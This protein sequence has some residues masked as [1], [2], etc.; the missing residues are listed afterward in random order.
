[1]PIDIN[2]VYSQ[3]RKMEVSLKE[4]S[5]ANYHYYQKILTKCDLYVSVISKYYA[6]AKQEF[7]QS[8]VNYNILE[9]EID[10]KRRHHIT[11]DESIQKKYS[12]GREREMA[13]EVLL[14]DEISQLKKKGN[15][16]ILLKDLCGVLNTWLSIMR[17]RKRDAKEQWK[18]LC[19]QNKASNMPDATDK[20]VK[21]LNKVIGELEA[22]A[23]NSM[24]EDLQIDE[25]TNS[26]EYIEDDQEES[27]DIIDAAKNDDSDVD[28]NISDNSEESEDI[29]IS[30]FDSNTAETI[31]PPTETAVSDETDPDSSDSEDDG[32]DILD[33]L[34]SDQDSSAEEV[35]SNQTLESPQPG[36]KEDNKSNDTLEDELLNDL[37]EIDE[38]IIA[39]VEEKKKRKKGSKKSGKSKKSDDTTVTSGKSDQEQTVEDS[40]GESTSDTDTQSRQKSTENP[41]NSPPKKDNVPNEDDASIANDVSIEDILGDL[42][43][44]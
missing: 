26:D 17:E 31:E 28:V 20:D 34:S 29:D 35:T 24:D 30:D 3:L 8:Q 42:D 13:V 41:G 36:A 16:L 27:E 7:S 2:A 14:K 38:S 6:L 32:P 40:A 18:I 4:Q 22:E 44:I 21:E 25:E 1:M 5:H 33:M 43:E 37:D 23:R 15:K 9:E 39:G 12:T 19:E 10:N 11:E